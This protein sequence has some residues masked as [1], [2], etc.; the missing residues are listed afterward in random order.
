VP[1]RLVVAGE[2]DRGL[3]LGGPGHGA[4]EGGPFGRVVELSPGEGYV[5]CGHG[6]LR[7][8]VVMMRWR[9]SSYSFANGNCVEWR[10]SSYSAGAGE[11]VEVA[12]AVQVRDSQDPGGAVLAFS[13][14][15][16]AAFTGRLRRE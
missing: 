13:P 10:T 9:K 15:A 3:L 7:K 8:V 1:Q 4:G 14:A 6:T 2:R 11:C 5:W 16:W 12:G